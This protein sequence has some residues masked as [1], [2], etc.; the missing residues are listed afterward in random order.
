MEEFIRIQFKLGRIDE[1]GVRS[2]VP[3]WITSAQAEKII[4]EK[5]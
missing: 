2:Y 3:R 4:Q 5:G 1:F